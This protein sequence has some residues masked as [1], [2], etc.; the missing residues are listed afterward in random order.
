M[1][2][3]NSGLRISRWCLRKRQPWRAFNKGTFCLMSA[4]SCIQQTTLQFALWHIVGGK[5]TQ[6]K[7]MMAL[8]VTFFFFF[9][10]LDIKKWKRKFSK[11]DYL[12]FLPNILYLILEV[13]EIKGSKKI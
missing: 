12:F 11:F 9:C 1:A 7:N 6:S 4:I 2:A 8:F 10:F 13:I 3:F 5:N